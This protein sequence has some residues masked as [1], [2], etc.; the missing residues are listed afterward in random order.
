MFIAQSRWFLPYQLEDH[1][2]RIA[3]AELATTIAQRK[4]GPFPSSDNPALTGTA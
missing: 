3:K 1:A 2:N 4:A